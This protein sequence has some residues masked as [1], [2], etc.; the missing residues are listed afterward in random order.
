MWVQN[1]S[2][3][4][5]SKRLLW[6]ITFKSKDITSRNI[7]LVPVGTGITFTLASKRY[8]TPGSENRRSRP[9]PVLREFNHFNLETKKFLPGEIK[10]SRM[11][12]VKGRQPEQRSNYPLHVY[13]L[14]PIQSLLL[15]TV[16]FHP[17]MH[18]IRQVGQL[19]TFLLLKQRSCS[20][21]RWCALRLI[22]QL[23]RACAMPDRTVADWLCGPPRHLPTSEQQSLCLPPLL[24][25]GIDKTFQNFHQIIKQRKVSKEGS[26]GQLL[27]M[28]AG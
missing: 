17:T 16:S 1:S 5:Q 18:N 14:L 25:L 8:C 12:P 13:G 10:F 27:S 6:V 4:P 7:F 2:A 23:P 19:R 20:P 15:F 22:A 9:S 24:S 21:G 28:P 11:I 26:P 3:E